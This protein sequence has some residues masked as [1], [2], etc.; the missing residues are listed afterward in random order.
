M[1]ATVT[2]DL[3]ND[4]AQTALDHHCLGGYVC[5]TMKE[6]ADRIQWNAE[7]GDTYPVI[8]ENG[9]S[10]GKLRISRR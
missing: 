8:D 9:N 2:I 7:P 5:D 1:K 3:D 6:T 4:A 10:I